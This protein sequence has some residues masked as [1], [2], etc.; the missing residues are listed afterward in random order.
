MEME[1][2]IERMMREDFIHFTTSH[3][4]QPIT[5]EQLTVDQVRQMLYFNQLHWI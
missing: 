2:L 3:F 5:E 4:N 1:K